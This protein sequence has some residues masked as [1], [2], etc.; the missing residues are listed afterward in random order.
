MADE[1][2]KDFYHKTLNSPAVQSV[3]KMRAI[4][5]QKAYSGN[6]GIDS[7]EW[8]RTITKKINLLKRVDD[9]LS[10]RNMELIGTLITNIKKRTIPIL[11]F[12]TLF[13]IGMITTVYLDQQRY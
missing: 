3:N 10:R 5:K 11:I 7:E 4:A 1:A 2:S 8:F 13:I 6:F 9:E 12:Y